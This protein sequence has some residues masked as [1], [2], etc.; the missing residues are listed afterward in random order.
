[1]F[2]QAFSVR[3]GVASGRDLAQLCRE[4]YPPLMVR[5]LWLMAEAAIAA[6]DLAEVLGTA[7]ALDLLFGIPLTAGVLITATD[8]LLLLTLAGRSA[9]A[10]EGII[11]ALL[12]VIGGCFIFTLAKAAP[13]ARPVLAGFI[14]RTRILTNSAELY[15]AIGILGA[16]VMPHNLYL[17]S[18]IVQSR[19]FEKDAAGR[20]EAVA[21]AT[22]DSHLALIYAGFVNA[23]ILVVAATAFRGQ[24][25]AVGT[26]S[27]AAR[28]LAPALGTAAATT[29]FGVGLLAAGQQST[30][31]GTL[32][33][34]V[35]MEGFLGPSMTLK[36]WA[37][38][39]LTRGIALVPAVAIAATAGPRGVN[40]LLNASQVALSLQL[41]F[42]IAPLVHFC[43]SPDVMGPLVISR[44]TRCLGWLLFLVISAANAKLVVDFISGA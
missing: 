36:P 27:E 41:P 1:M 13:P 21:Y 15:A 5:L 30:L 28:L 31:T 8:V 35:V 38:R 19:A 33:G 18:A 25:E 11:A 23:A 44:P 9:R 17:H 34:Q 29:V 40:A 16:T 39:L 6:C 4:R 22:L 24:Q 7:I 14:P 26:L 37:R 3:L 43:G 32:A 10:L 42:A 2:L 20:R 12:L